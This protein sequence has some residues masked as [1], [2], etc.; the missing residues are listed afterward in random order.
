MQIVTIFCVLLSLLSAGQ[1]AAQPTPLRIGR[2][3][4]LFI[5]DYIVATQSG[6][7]K[8]LHQPKKHTANP[9]LP[10]VP[11]GE[12]DWQQ[13]MPISF[14][15]VLFDEE[16]A[17]F[18]LWYSLHEKG[19]SDS[20]AVLA[21]AT[22]YDGHH[23][24]TPTLGLHEYRGTWQNNVVIPSQ[25][26]ECGILKDDH[27]RN[28]AK[29]YKMLYPGI[30]AAYSADGLHWQD[31][32][33][34]ERVIFHA[35]GHD[36][37]SVPYWDED[38]GK[39]VA[40]IRD[41]TGMIKRVRT[42]LVTDPAARAGWKELWGGEGKKRSP[43]SHSIRQVGQVE[44]DDFLHWTPMRTIVAPDASD[45]PNRD[46]FYNMQVLLYEGLRLGFVTVFSYDPEYC[47]GAVQ[48]TY[49]R[50]GLNWERAANRA[51]FLPTSDNPSDVDWGAVYPLQG[52]IVLGDEIW[53]YYNGYAA[54]HNHRLY[55]GVKGFPNGICLAKLRLDGFVSV[56][57]GA[58]EGT[59]T[60]K[61][62]ALEGERLELNADARDGHVLVEI[63]DDQSQPLTGLTKEDC[64]PLRTD[65]LR[66][67]V[68]WAGNSR[69]GV[70]RSKPIQL[71]FYLREAKLFSFTIR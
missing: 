40:I 66:H 61:P 34:G 69:L 50:D 64:V 48:L 35:P 25:G 57:A 45:P 54:D 41:R 42:I 30:R 58:D 14:S 53:I 22:S 38:L 56:G 39:Y 68:E 2:Q 63:L 21:Y 15:T 28:P 11:A 7:S 19:E 55:P 33:D 18:K 70:A 46:Q 31:Y 17:M 29:R 65:R 10:M 36:S 6:I 47:R 37:Q 5:D 67:V 8:T 44:S 60:T 59:L 27:E 32:N 12:S 52:P 4:Q 13:G 16:T 9:I 26:L 3:K 20:Q 23:W 1:L 43:E 62:F 24:E 51:V 71:R 49:S